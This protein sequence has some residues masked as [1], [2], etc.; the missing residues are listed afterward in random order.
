MN[1]MSET[2]TKSDLTA[3]LGTQTEVIKRNLNDRFDHY[4]KR[5]GAYHVEIME[6]FA[7]IIENVNKHTTAEFNK[8]REDLD[9]RQ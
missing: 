1:S 6:G 5:Q 2:L 8:L 3:A 7:D 9:I 4:E